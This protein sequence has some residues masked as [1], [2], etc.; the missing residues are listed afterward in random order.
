[1]ALAA[2][3]G[4]SVAL[5]F[6]EVDRFKAINQTL[7]FEESDDLWLQFSRRLALPL[8]TGDTLA[9]LAHDQYGILLPELRDALEP[10]RFAQS[11]LDALAI[12]FR[13][14]S[15]ELNLTAS[16]GISM[17]PQD[18]AEVL[19]LLKQAES[20]AIR[21]RTEGGNTFRCSTPTLNEASLERR[22]MEICLGEAIT[23]HE[24]SLLFQPQC[25]ADG[26]IVGLEALVRWQHPVL[27]SVPPSK[28]IPLAEENQLI[29]PIGE[30]VLRNA[31]RKMV[32]WQALSPRPL[33]LAVNVSPLQ[34]G[35][36]HWVDS[37]SRIIHEF[38]MSPRCLEIEITE[39]TLLR[40]AKLNDTALHMIKAMGIR[41][42]I[43]DFGT[44][45]SSLNYL[46]RLP[47]DTLKIDLSFVSG[48]RPEHPDISSIPIV[49]SILDL[50]R[51]LHLDVVAEGV[52]TSMQRDTLQRM[53]CQIYQG[54]LM[55]APM[56]AEQ[57]EAQLEAQ[58]I[59]V[60]NTLLSSGSQQAG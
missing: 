19:P 6:V 59:R 30:W 20:A 14:G 12:P 11:L 49:Q 4:H 42:G 53:G 36:A 8:R 32:S 26:T 48:L 43:D 57:I 31:C 5:I 40:H 16:I 45:Y 3:R 1:I 60:F 55:G 28:F 23:K 7:N 2:R 47:I 50:G 15:R 54:Y 56:T 18:G 38:K 34:V 24:L 39:G 10:C 27:G 33:R 9:R 37:V 25:T 52:E 58:Q 17:C 44:G 22:E 21:S 13:L 35:Q 29:H 46:H 51:N 41:I